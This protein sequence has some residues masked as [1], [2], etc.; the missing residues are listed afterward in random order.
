MWTA[1]CATGEEAYS[2]ALLACEAFA[3]APAPVSILATDISPDA[4]VRARLGVYGPRSVRELEPALRPRY[5][6]EQP[7]GLVA[8][9]RLRGLVTFA[10]HNLVRDVFP[11]LGET[12][13]QVI[14]CRNVLI[15]F[16]EGD[17][18]DGWS[19]PSRA[20]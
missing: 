12:E 16:D 15:Y 7:A 20:R 8:G 17:R 18:G 10:R 5:L 11:P 19:R 6:R 1:A 14:L 3:P 9:E 4:L 13:V 2:L